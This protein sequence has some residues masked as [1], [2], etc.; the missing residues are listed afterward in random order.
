MALPPA[1]IASIVSAVID[2]TTQ[3]PGNVQQYQ[4][5]VRLQKLPPEAKVGLMQP[6]SNDGSVL[7]DSDRLRLSPAIQIRNLQN[8]IVVP[9]NVTE[10]TNVVYLN[11]LYGSVHRVWMI[12]SS[13]AE[14]LRPLEPIQ[15]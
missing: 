2:M 5:Y 4:E 15:P 13:E 3:L 1:V 12:T 11:D 7:I 8:L 9:M 14:S 6:P 10:T